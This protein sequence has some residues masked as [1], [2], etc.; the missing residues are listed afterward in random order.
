M[1]EHVYLIVDISTR[2]GVVG[3][4]LCIDKLINVQ[5]NESTLQNF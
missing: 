3:T 4:S 5:H 1:I 2:S